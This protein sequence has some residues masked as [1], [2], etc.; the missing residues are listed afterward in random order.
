[1]T[2]LLDTDTLVF[3]LRGRNDIRK[4]LLGVPLSE[5]CTSSVCVGE[6]YYGAAKSQRRAERKAEV[7]S[8]RELLLAIPLRTAETERFGELK[9]AL[10]V[11]GERLADA[12]LMIA[13]TALEHNLVVI[14]GNLSHFE[15][16][17]GLQ[18]E[19]WIE[20]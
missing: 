6:L 5:L 11:R 9:A 20:R 2:Y 3:Y 4:K 1:M 7:D 16:I 19:N 12:D 14:T 8:L 13:A 15:R 18:V 10:E 17:S